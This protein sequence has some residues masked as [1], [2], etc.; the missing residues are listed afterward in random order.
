ML[1]WRKGHGDRKAGT[2]SLFP[3]V[4]QAHPGKDAAA[5]TGRQSPFFAI[6]AL[7]AVAATVVGQPALTSIQDVLYRADGTRFTGTMFI[8]YNSFLAGDTTN[9][10]TAN[11]TLPI[12]NGVLRVQLVPTTTASA[13]AQYTVTYNSRGIDQ[14]TEIWAVAPSTIPLRVRDVRVSSG[15]VI[16]PPPVVSPVQISDVTGLPNELSVRPMKGIGFGIGR[17][18]VINQA[19]QIDAASGNLG[20]CVRVDGSSGP[21]GGGGGAAGSSFADG[22]IPSGTIN[23]S[24]T[25][26]TLASAPSPASSLEL[27]RNGLLMRQGTD[28][29]ISTNTITFFLASVPQSGDLL[30]ASYR[31][32][33]PNDPL[34]SLASPQVVCSSTGSSTSGVSLV[35]LGSCTIAA[36]L[37]GAGDRIEIHFQYAH[38]GT[39]TG[40]TGAVQMGGTTIVSR[41]G[42]ASEALLAGH[43]SVGMY[44]GGQV[45]DTQTW[46]I[47]MSLATNAGTTGEDTS[48]GLRVSLKGQMAG[49]TSDSVFLR[50]FT[51]LRYP[52]Q[53]NP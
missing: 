14:F 11:L 13:G 38:T 32:A 44:G 47:A 29:Q 21:C 46:G 15:T 51:V 6:F 12:V 19:G 34:S 49:T 20:D 16:G 31:F 52:A 23:G 41:T 4:R 45:W 1:S 27:Y 2:A 26:F 30:V 24:N 40:F 39:A 48:Q 22:E 25:N 36:G 43:T 42:A 7:F 37:M 8:R 10:A 28:Y 18:A 50:N 9:I 35:E 3:R 33:N 17:T 5:K 53:S